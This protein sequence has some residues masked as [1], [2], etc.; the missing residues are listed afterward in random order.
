M[1]YR[2]KNV[3]RATVAALRAFSASFRPATAEIEMLMVGARVALK[4]GLRLI[5]ILGLI[6]VLVFGIRQLL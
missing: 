4:L 5:V 6:G 2:I 1:T 3:P